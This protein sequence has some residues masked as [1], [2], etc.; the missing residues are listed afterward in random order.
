MHDYLNEHQKNAVGALECLKKI[1][2]ENG[3]SFYLLA[4]TA[5]G[6]VRHKGMI[7][8]DDDID[9]GLRY[10]DW[11]KLRKILPDALKGTKYTYVDD[12]VDKKFP[13]M[14]GKII[15]EGQGCIDIFLIVKWTPNR[16]RGYIHWQIRR[17]A[18]LFYQ[19]SVHIQKVKGYGFKIKPLKWK[20]RYYVVYTMRYI[21]YLLTR[22]FFG[23]DDYVKLARWNEKFFENKDTGW[24][25]NL[26]S[27]YTMQKEMLKAEWIDKT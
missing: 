17:C 6:A 14:F 20:I 1:C 19:I 4:G 16:F 3:I 9:V 12:E 23:R 27:I 15:C 8:W 2:D 10:D 11:Y 13:R 22:I 5:L 24:Y 7:P 26:Y 25:I 21:L 18:V